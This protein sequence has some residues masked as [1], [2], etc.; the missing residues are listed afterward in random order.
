MI[1]P[2]YLP[3]Q[4]MQ[5]ALCAQIDTEIFYPE[6]GDPASADMARRVCNMCDVKKQCLQ[7]AVDNNERHGIWGGTI[8]RERR[9][10]FK[11]KGVAC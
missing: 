11:I 2:A 9:H 4:W 6:Q 3:P 8:E 1:N 10:L 5:S 7:Y